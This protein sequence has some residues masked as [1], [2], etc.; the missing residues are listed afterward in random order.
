[1]PSE[2]EWEKAARG[3]DGRIYPWGSAPVTAFANFA[4]SA[5]RPVG[6]LPCPDCTFGLADMS[7]NVWELTRSPLQP[8]PFDLSDHPTDTAAP[9]LFVIRGGAFDQAANNVR[10]AVRGGVDPGA[11]RAFVG[12]RLVLTPALRE[13]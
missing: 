7:G 3:D 6:S 9:A 2:A 8:Y 10:A 4:G 12:F 13:V 5:V 1:M 11:R